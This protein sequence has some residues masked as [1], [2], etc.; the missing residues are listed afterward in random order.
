[1]SLV[2]LKNVNYKYPQ[3]QT[4]ALKDISIEINKGEYIALAGLN[5]SGKSTLARLIAG[6]IQ[7]ESGDFTVEKNTLPGIVFQQPKEQIVA[8]IVERDTAF[9]PQNLNMSKAEIELRTIECLTVVGIAD[10][11]MNRTFELS[12]G[13][14]Q[15]LAFSGILAL[16]PSLLIL[17]EVTAM[18]D[19]KAREELVEF[20]RQWNAK[21]HTV[22]HVTHDEDEVLAAGRVIVLDKGRKIFDGSSE[23]FKKAAPVKDM[24]FDSGDQCLPSSK[25]NLQERETSLKVENLSFSYEGYEVFKNLSFE[26]KKGSLVALTG[27][28]GCGKS[29]LFECLAG[30]KKADSGSIKG[31]C[32]PALALQESEAALFERYAADDVAFGAIN[33]GFKGKE[34]VRRVKS[35]MEL[36]GLNY[37]EYGNRSSFNLSGG[38]KRKLSIAGI[39]A[40]NR[41]I[42]IFDE[43][44]SALDG[45]SRKTV[46][47]T[48]RQLADEGKTVLFSTHRMEEAAAAD[49]HILWK[50]LIATKADDKAGLEAKEDVKTGTQ[51]KNIEAAS[52]SLILNS[53]QKLTGVLTAP[54]KVPSSLLSDKPAWLKTLIFLFLFTASLAVQSVSLCAIMLG[55]NFIYA[56]CSSFSLKKV[57]TALRKLLP[58]ILFFLLLEFIF[59]PVSKGDSEI[60]RWKFI[61]ISEYK[62]L[63]SVKTL[64]RALCSVTCVAVFISSTS[65]REI[66]DGLSGVLLPLA[67]AGVPV[68]YLVLVTG[69]IF[70][71]MPLL[72]DE[73]SAIIKTQIVRGAFSHAKGLKKL[74]IL[75][76][77][78]VPL[79]LQTFR[80][81][82]FLA[83]A[84][85]ARYF[86]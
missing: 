44:T 52:N 22:I 69:I 63:L 86:K 70:R 14:T 66:L 27:P 15:R 74:K 11:A 37:K 76:P 59:Y 2:S 17:D 5:G 16:F 49:C 57:F 25:I 51:L 40:L 29:T 33:E 58:F 82:Q 78:F 6:F 24:L 35:S 36:A 1:M 42:L 50:D 8:G 60:F 20:I 23:E 48:L 55:L 46:L 65:E 28:S 18:L 54:A 12:L 10:K 77:L 43:P 3:C 53:I 38:E 31:S 67:K 47:R 61:V 39:I 79:M 71:F 9:G 7:P 81:A 26:L 41:D 84:L 32:I 72:L 68:R 30:L 21:G 73:L 62:I 75:I 83:D 13:Q 80:K 56:L 4:P 19:P 34:L 85:T 64:I 45:V